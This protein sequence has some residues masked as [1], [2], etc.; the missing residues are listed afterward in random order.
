M[1]EPQSRPGVLL[2]NING[3]GTGHLST[4]LAYANRL[5][6]RARPVFF[7]LASAIDAIHGMGFEAEYFVSRFWS[8]ATALAWDRQLAE[9]LGLVLE[10]VRP[11]VIVF[12][13]NWP[14][15]GL[16]AAAE[17]YGQAKLVWSNLMMFKPGTRSVPVSER[18]FD[19]VIRLGEIG[20]PVEVEQEKGLRRIHIPPATILKNDQLLNRDTA[21]DHLGLEQGGRYV[22]MSLGPG[23]LKAVGSIARRLSARFQ[24]YGYSVVWARGPIS[25]RDDAMPEGAMTISEY[26]LARF[27]RAFDI[28]VGAA[29]YNSTCEVVQAR[30][31]ALLV[32]NLQVADDQLR[33]A[34]LMAG[35]SPAVVSPCDTEDQ[36]QASVAEVVSMVSGRSSI[37]GIPDLSGADVAAEEILALANRKL[38]V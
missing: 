32:P 3:N 4:C 36:I 14:Y 23:N 17:A 38:P 28:Y 26:P 20:T 13:G 5:R 9:R 2:F 24:K 25:R 8:R 33:R 34:H 7:S 21:R 12:D 31:P 30:L 35:C 37:K 15:R 6:D 22:L 1:S 11:A 16:F 19:L 29:G 18:H 10:H 27:L